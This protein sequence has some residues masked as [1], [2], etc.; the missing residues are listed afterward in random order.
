MSNEGVAFQNKYLPAG[1]VSVK[2][3]LAI[4][5][6]VYA[7]G[8]PGY[9][10]AEFV[11]TSGTVDL[12]D[13][14][15]TS[16]TVTALSAGDCPK[17]CRPYVTQI[18]MQVL[19]GLGWS[20]TS[21]TAG[22]VPSVYLVDSISGTPLLAVPFAALDTR[23]I[24]TFPQAETRVPIFLGEAA[25]T[26]IVGA[27]AA[28]F[29]YVPSTGIITASATMFVANVGV[30][31]I[32]EVIAG[33]G[34]GQTSIITAVTATTITC[35]PALTS[36]VNDHASS[37]KDTVLAIHNQTVKTATDT[38]HSTIQN[39]GGTGFTANAFDSGLNVLG[40][41]GTGAGQVRQIIANTTA[42]ALTYNGALSTNFD[43]T[44]SMLAITD[45]VG[46]GEA[47]QCGLASLY[48]ITSPYNLATN[49]GAGLNWVV[50][51]Q[52][53]TSPVGASIRWQLWGYF[54]P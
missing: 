14:A 13:I 26:N 51:N 45:N 29:T 3:G 32:V 37:A 24:L 1:I 36:A 20:N 19:G 49:I 52:A 42:G 38:T 47:I 44:T 53:G 16:T 34:V 21:P 10:A 27:P 5:Q 48:P 17:N 4:K 41:I 11:R 54:G 33:G 9:E 30:G 25:N 43:T 46:V 7:S 6:S 28:T 18:A 39:A 22:S 12:P 15:S 35:V 50:N 23:A 8:N 31:S 40:V 2:G